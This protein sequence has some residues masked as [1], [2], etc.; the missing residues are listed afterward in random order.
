MPLKAPAVYP[1]DIRSFDQ[2]TR[3]VAVTPDPDSVTTIS[4]ADG[5]ITN[6]KF[7]DSLPNSIIGRAAGSDGA[8]ADIQATVGGQ[9]LI[10]RS[11]ALGFDVLE[12]SDIPSTITRDTEVTAAI[13]ALQ[14]ETDPFPQ[15]V[16]DSTV[17][18]GS[19]AYNPP[20][21]AN[22]AGDSK[23]ITVAG[24]ALNDFVLWSFSLDIQSM[25]VWAWVSAA[26]TVTVRFL[27]LT[28]ATLD[29]GAGNLNC[30]VWKQ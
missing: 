3:D 4:V 14:A 16:L 28:G 10:F 23:T 26:N 11:G 7:R 1:G 29:L 18:N 27:N 6:D 9:L 30:R 15:Y 12:D 8:P 25:T 22:G 5:S 2:W 20:S 19:A 21:L 13:T 17:L 24:A